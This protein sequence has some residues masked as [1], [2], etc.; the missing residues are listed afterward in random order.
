MNN[1]MQ[2][3][4][5]PKCGH[6]GGS[7]PGSEPWC[8]KCTNRVRMQPAHNRTILVVDEV[9]DTWY[10][11]H[12]TAGCVYLYTHKVVKVTPKGVWV[13]INEFTD[14]TKFILKYAV[15]RFACPTE[16]LA[17]ESFIHRKERQ[18]TIMESQMK[19]VKE[20][21]GRAK[22]GVIGLEV[23]LSPFNFNISDKLC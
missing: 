20:S 18:L 5:C 9:G 23:E 12:D 13:C 7:P 1:P 17:M 22:R 15:K 21:L 19:S 11:Y 6:G 14:E 3:Y 16:K 8:S 10:R 2:R 4:I